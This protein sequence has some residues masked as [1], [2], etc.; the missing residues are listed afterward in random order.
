MVPF[1]Y[2]VVLLL[3]VTLGIWFRLGYIVVLLYAT[4]GIWLRLGY[5]VVLLLYVTLDIWFGLVIELYC[6]CV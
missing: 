3:Y 1:G 6:C 2:R 5:R 4:L